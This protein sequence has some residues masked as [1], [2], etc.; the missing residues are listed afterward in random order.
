MACSSFSSISSTSLILL[1]IFQ[2]LLIS[3]SKDFKF[4]SS[5][6]IILLLT[7]DQGLSDIGYFDSQFSTPFLDSLSLNGIK[8]NRMYTSTTCSPSR[9]VL[10]T[11]KHVNRIGVQDGP[12]VIGEGRALSLNFTLLPQHLRDVGYR[13]VGIGKW[14]RIIYYFNTFFISYSTLLLSSSFSS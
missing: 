7:D 2:Y 12:F 1:I 14:S 3:L 5:P 8:I 6:H 10:L 11:G 9:S 13:T 4:S